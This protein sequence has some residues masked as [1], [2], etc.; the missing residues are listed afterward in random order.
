MCL[1]LPLYATSPANGANSQDFE[2]LIGWVGK[3]NQ[4]LNQF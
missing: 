4:K 2:V 1:T 3:T